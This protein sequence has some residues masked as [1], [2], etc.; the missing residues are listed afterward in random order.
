M[1]QPTLSEHLAK[2]EALLGLHLAQ[3]LISKRN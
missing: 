1:E 2:Y 3:Q